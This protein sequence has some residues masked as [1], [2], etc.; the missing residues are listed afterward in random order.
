MCVRV[1]ILL[2]FCKNLF[3]QRATYHFEIVLQL[4]ELSGKCNFLW[5]KPLLRKT[6]NAKKIQA[7]TFFIATCWCWGENSRLRLVVIV[8][9]LAASIVG[10]NRTTSLGLTACSGHPRGRAWKPDERITIRLDI[11]RRTLRKQVWNTMHRLKRKG[12]TPPAYF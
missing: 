2:K 9:A 1:N 12:S 7:L 4:L 10:T 6:E 5:I 11:Q 8:K 3:L